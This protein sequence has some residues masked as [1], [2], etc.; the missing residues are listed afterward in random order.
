M[1]NQT[2][3]KRVEAISLESFGRPFRHQA[4]FNSRLRTT[5][6]RYRLADHNLDFN[7][8]MAELP[9]FDQIIKHELVHYHLHLTHRGYQHRDADFK[10]LLKAVG[11]SRYAPRLEGNRR[12]IKRWRYECS[13]GH[14]IERQRRF[15]TRRYRCGRCGGRLTLLNPQEN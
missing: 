13:S 3:Q 12:S 10:A 14:I 11:G 7:P 9:E 15:D 6:G 1:D 2:L 4:T 5:G 8:R